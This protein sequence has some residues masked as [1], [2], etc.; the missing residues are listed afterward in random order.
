MFVLI[1]EQKYSHE[2]EP[3]ICLLFFASCR[4]RHRYVCIWRE[5]TD[6]EELASTKVQTQKKFNCCVLCEQLLKGNEKD[7]TRLHIQVFMHLYV[8]VPRRRHVCM[9]IFQIAISTCV[10]PRYTICIFGFQG[11]LPTTRLARISFLISPEFYSRLRDCEGSSNNLVPRG[12]KVSAIDVTPKTI[13]E[14]LY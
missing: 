7:L 1:T 8:N 3:L 2:I 14:R 12:T 4:P 11:A 10:S 13:F 5:Q 9:C 6:R